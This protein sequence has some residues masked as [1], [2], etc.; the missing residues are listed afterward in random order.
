V[1]TPFFDAETPFDPN[2]GRI[3]DPEDVSKVVLDALALPERALVSE[4][5]IRPS[6]P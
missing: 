1:N 6:N 2:R 4:L 3:L 5:D